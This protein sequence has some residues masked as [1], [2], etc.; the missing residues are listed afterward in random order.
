M[1]K[2]YYEILGINKSATLA[3]IKTAYKKKALESHPDKNHNSKEATEKFKKIQEAYSILSDTNERARYDRYNDDKDFSPPSRASAGGLGTSSFNKFTVEKSIRTFLEINKL[4]GMEKELGT[5]YQQLIPTNH[6]CFS[7]TSLTLNYWDI[8]ITSCLDTEDE[9]QNFQDRFISLVNEYLEEVKFMKKQTY[10]EL[11]NLLNTASSEARKCIE[12]YCLYSHGSNYNN[13]REYFLNEPKWSKKKK[14][15]LWFRDN[16]RDYFND[17]IR[18][19]RNRM[20]RKEN[21]PEAT[22]AERRERK[23]K[24]RQNRIGWHDSPFS[25]TSN[26]NISVEEEI[27]RAEAQEKVNHLENKQ[28]SGENLTADEQR[29]LSKAEAELTRI[30]NKSGKNPKGKDNEFPPELIG[31]TIIAVLII[32]V[33]TIFVKKRKKNAILNTKV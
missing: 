12:N 10:D 24:Q 32:G 3:E 26:P 1:A 16:M 29:Q 31:L 20:G 4:Y 25:S 7:H 2:K 13:F 6:S 8:H 23:E 30:N 21:Y 18:I 22:E 14:N 33:I 27:K 17:V 11:E 15:V 5:K 9:I 28:N 19:S